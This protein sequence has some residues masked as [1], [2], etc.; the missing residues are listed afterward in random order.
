MDLKKSIGYKIYSLRMEY[1]LKQEE[2]VAK[3]NPTF[4]RA[5]LSNIENGLS[6]PSAEFIKAVCTAFNLSSDWLL[7]INNLPPKSVFL[8]KFNRL[9]KDAQQTI[10]NLMDLILKD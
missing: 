7:D 10:L 9:D 1:E 6:M 4:S 2:F 5:N 8:Q 3:L